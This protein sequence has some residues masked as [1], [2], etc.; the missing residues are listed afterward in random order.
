MYVMGRP[1]CVPAGIVVSQMICPV[2]LSYARNMGWPPHPSPANNSVFVTR[3][4]ACDGLPVFG[5]FRPLS[6]GLF[7][8]AG[9]VSPL[10][11]CQAISPLFMSYAVMRPYGGFINGRPSILGRPSPPPLL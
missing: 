9:G 5:M 6:A 11:I 10:G 8:I 4:P 3:M 2:A 7:L 1:L